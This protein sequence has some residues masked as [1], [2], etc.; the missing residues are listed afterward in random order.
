MNNEFC[1]PI[2]KWL[3][4]KNFGQFECHYAKGEW[5]FENKEISNFCKF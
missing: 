2:T 5:C 4:S 1:T 3:L